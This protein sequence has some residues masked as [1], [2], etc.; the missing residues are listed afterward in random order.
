MDNEKLALLSVYELCELLAVNLDCEHLDIK[1]FKNCDFAIADE[2][3]VRNDVDLETIK[4]NSSGWY[5]IKA[6]DPGFD[7]DDIMIITDS[8]ML[9]R[10]PV[11]QISVIGRTASGVIIM[12][13]SENAI[14]TGFQV[15]QKDENLAETVVDED[16]E[17]LSF[18]DTDSDSDSD[19][20]LEIAPEA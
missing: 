8:G 16:I 20:D 3:Y 9:I 5:G 15:I 7:S 18:A 2:C 6:V 1:D 14:I 4:Y 17:E 13:T 11:S 12:R 10:I 19:S